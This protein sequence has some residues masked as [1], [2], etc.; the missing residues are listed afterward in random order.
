MTV[1]NKTQFK[2]HLQMTNSVCFFFEY[3]KLH[4]YKG[5]E[6]VAFFKILQ[7]LR[8]TKI[9]LWVYQA[10]FFLSINFIVLMWSQKRVGKNYADR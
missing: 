2:C 9:S 6:L 1:C 5:M 7:S 8:A 3:E 10:F 4:S